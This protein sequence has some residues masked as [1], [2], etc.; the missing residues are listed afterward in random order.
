MKV[1]TTRIVYAC[2]SL[3]IFTT[4][5]LQKINPGNIGTCISEYTDSLGTQ[6]YVIK[7][8]IGNGNVYGH[9]NKNSFEEIGGCE[10]PNNIVY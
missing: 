2:H 6:V 3:N 1:R 10:I 8:A 7:F 5:H 4:S 9:I